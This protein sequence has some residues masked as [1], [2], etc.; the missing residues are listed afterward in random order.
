MGKRMN[1]KQL[2][3]KFGESAN[4]DAP[5]RRRLGRKSDRTAGEGFIL[6]TFDFFHSIPRLPSENGGLSGRV[7]G[8]TQVGWVYTRLIPI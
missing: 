1:K 4:S 6:P 3:A 2:A 7:N 5:D 8:K